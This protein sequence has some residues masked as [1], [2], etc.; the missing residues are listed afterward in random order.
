MATIF[1]FIWFIFI[2]WWSV[3][4]FLILGGIFVITLVDI[5]IVK[6]LSQFT[7]NTSDRQSVAPFGLRL[8]VAELKGIANIIP[9]Q[10][11]IN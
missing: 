1:N 3:I 6:A 4:S 9:N 5:P 2:G 7:I 11:I 10:S 8:A